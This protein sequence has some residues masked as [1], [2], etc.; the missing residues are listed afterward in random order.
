M[1]KERG[2]GMSQMK[3]LTVTGGV[4]VLVMLLVG[5]AFADLNLE[6]RQKIVV[7]QPGTLESVQLLVVTLSGSQVVQTL[8]L[9]NAIAIELP[10]NGIEEALTF[11]LDHLAVAEV[12]DDLITRV[13]RIIPVAPNEEEVYDWGLVQIGVPTVHEE[14]PTRTGSG[15]TVAILDTGVDRR[16]PE[17]RGNIVRG[18]NARPHESSNADQHGHGT[19]IAGIIA[20]AL[21]D[22]GIVGM[23]PEVNIA[24][25][26]VLGPDGTGRTSHIIKGLEWVCDQGIRLVNLSLGFSHENPPLKEATKRFKEDCGGIMLAAS[27]NHCSDDPDQ[28]EGGDSEGEGCTGSQSEVKFPA[29]YPWVIAVGATTVD[30]KI[31]SYSQAGAPMKQTGVV[32][33]GGEKE[34]E[35][36]LSTY[37]GGGLGE[38][39]GTSQATAHV[40]GAVAL[41]LQQR[42]GLSFERVLAF[43]QQTARD[44]G[45]SDTEQGAGEIDVL[46]LIDE[47]K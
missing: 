32:A 13:N 20:A 14:M 31:P 34:G 26:K 12:L 47:V 10:V 29:L 42:S 7:F 24:A 44:L 11:L 39:S 5:H 35:R 16:H 9:I 38:G 4:F 18:Y 17:L 45:Y 40:T 3:R 41:L 43:L 1:V 21:N 6:D 30:G 15:V 25:V 22:K 27:G 8:S 19:H 2:E 23:A 46:A 33:P 36:I 28:E 37:P